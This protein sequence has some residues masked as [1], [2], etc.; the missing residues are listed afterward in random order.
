MEKET[1]LS[2]NLVENSNFEKD[3]TEDGKPDNWVTSG[4][5]SINDKAVQNTS[6]GDDNVYAGQGPN[7]GFLR[8]SPIVHTLDF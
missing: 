3:A 1:I 8:I 7:K 5:L 6:H 2:Y 4:N